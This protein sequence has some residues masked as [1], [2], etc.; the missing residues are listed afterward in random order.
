MAEEKRRHTAEERARLSADII[1]R[2]K[3][4][5][6]FTASDTVLLYHALPDEVQTDTLL[7]KWYVSKRLLLPVVCGDELELRVYRGP[8]HTQ[9]GAYGI[10]EPDGETFA[11]YAS[12]GLALIPGVAFDAAGNRL[13]RGKG[14]YDRLLNQLRQAGVH[15]VGIGFG[16][17]RVPHVPT[18]PHDIPMD[19]VL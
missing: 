2:I 4:H 18:E 3:A 1:R 7:L 13:G 11:D 15:T 9:T 14:Y 8:E 16:F 17:Q 10:T 6:L 12:I 5:P 19:E